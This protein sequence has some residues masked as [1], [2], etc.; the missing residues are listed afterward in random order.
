MKL[1]ENRKN[2]QIYRQEETES[3]QA[4]IADEEELTELIESVT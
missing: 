1:D 3:H 2:F 4:R